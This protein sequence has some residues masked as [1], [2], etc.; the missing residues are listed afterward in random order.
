MAAISTPAGRML[1][2]A[3]DQRNGMKA[4]MS[5]APDGPGSDTPDQLAD[6]KSD[7]V[8]YLGNHA[9]AILLD[10]E[11][12]LPPHDVTVVHLVSDPADDPTDDPVEISADG[13]HGSDVTLT[14]SLGAQMLLWETATAVAG[15]ILSIDPFNQPN[16]TESKENTQAILE[17]GLPDEPAVATDGAIEIRAS[18]GVLDGVD[19]GSTGAVRTALHALLAAIPEH[20]YLAAMAY[21]DALGEAM[22]LSAALGT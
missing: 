16:V 4:V 11:V 6:A 19:L 3:A 7:L 14:G 17:S 10:P 5:D 13:G 20:G 15:R 9:P 8:R 12:A 22:A 18:G 21:L 1:I 2:V